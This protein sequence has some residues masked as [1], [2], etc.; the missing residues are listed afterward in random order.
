ML[1]RQGSPGLENLCVTKIT[2][3][4]KQPRVDLNPVF[5]YYRTNVHKNTRLGFSEDSHPRAY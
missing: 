4:G 5:K 1:Y 2:E 3:L